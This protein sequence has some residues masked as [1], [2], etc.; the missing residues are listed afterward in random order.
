MAGVIC[1][2]LYSVI[3]TVTELT[4]TSRVWAVDRSTFVNRAGYF[5]CFPFDLDIFG[6]FGF[7]LVPFGT[8]DAPGSVA[9]CWATRAELRRGF[10]VDVPRINRIRTKQLAN[11][12]NLIIKEDLAKYQ[13]E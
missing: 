7:V 10:R 8:P 11:R 3:T 2:G 13:V 4:V 9:A 6:G 12:I 5:L 1:F